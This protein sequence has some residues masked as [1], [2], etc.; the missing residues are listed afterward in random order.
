MPPT[1]PLFTDPTRSVY[2]ALGM[3]RRTTDPGPENPRPDYVRHGY[4]PGIGMVVKN[5]IK[6]RR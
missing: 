1:V 5:A 2:L 3:C 4:W 6:V